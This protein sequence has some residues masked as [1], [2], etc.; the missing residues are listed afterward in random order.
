MFKAQVD[1]LVE[2]ALDQPNPTP[3]LKAALNDLLTAL[4][5]PARDRARDPKVVS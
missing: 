2:A 3:A 4:K 1:R 5:H